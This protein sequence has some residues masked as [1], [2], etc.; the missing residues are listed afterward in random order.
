MQVTSN[1][2]YLNLNI[3]ESKDITLQR[4]ENAASVTSVLRSVVWVCVLLSPFHKSPL[5][6]GL[7]PIY[8]FCFLHYFA[9]DCDVRFLSGT[10][11]QVCV[12]ATL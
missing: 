5:L 3:V 12:A 1:A 6:T 9:N 10:V 4:R 11:Q 8:D 2:G 7:I